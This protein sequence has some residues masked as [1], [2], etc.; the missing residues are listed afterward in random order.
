MNLLVNIPIGPKFKGRQI[1]DFWAPD[2]YSEIIDWL[3]Y[4]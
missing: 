3:R 4:C 1:Q 2:F